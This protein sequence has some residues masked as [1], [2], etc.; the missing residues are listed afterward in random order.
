MLDVSWVDEQMERVRCATA[1][2]Q[3]ARDYALL[4]IARDHL[5]PKET[6]ERR[7]YNHGVLDTAPTL[8]Q[9]EAALSAITV[10]TKEDRDRAGDAKTWV[11]ILK[12]EE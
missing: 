5:A 11:Q 7:P 6:E 2:M 1:T 9:V 8:D 10:T 3:T 4:C 12:K